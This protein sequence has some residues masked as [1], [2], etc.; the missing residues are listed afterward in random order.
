MVHQIFTR[1]LLA[2][3]VLDVLGALWMRAVARVAR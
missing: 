3:A 2:A 1:S